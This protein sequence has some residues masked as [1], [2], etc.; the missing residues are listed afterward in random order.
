MVVRSEQTS[1]GF[2]V[3]RNDMRLVPWGFLFISYN[4]NLELKIHKKPQHK[5]CACWQSIGKEGTLVRQ[6]F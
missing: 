3:L 5:P 6:S 1:Y 4:L 2:W